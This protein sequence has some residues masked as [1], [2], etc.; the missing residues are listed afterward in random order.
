MTNLNPNPFLGAGIRRVA[1]IQ[2]VPRSQSEAVSNQNP[3]A[4]SEGP[5]KNQLKTN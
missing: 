3:K 2:A 4:I 1:R 5:T